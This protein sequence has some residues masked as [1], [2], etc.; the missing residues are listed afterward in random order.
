MGR[1]L[2]GLTDGENM[3]NSLNVCDTFTG[4]TGYCIPQ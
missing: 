1:G 2:S 3:T 4:H